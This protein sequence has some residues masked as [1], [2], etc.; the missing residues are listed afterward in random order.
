MEEK[1]LKSFAEVLEIENSSIL[2]TSTVFRDLPEWN[3]LAYLSLIAM[4]DEEYNVVIDGNEFRKLQ[5]IGDIIKA[6]NKSIEN[7]PREN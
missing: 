2:S 6:V 5:T 4:I 3:S 1:F 7:N